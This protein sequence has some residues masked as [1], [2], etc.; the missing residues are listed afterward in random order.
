MSVEPIMASAVGNGR[1]LLSGR[2]VAVEVRRDGAVSN[3]P[4]HDRSGIL[5]PRAVPENPPR[6]VKIYER[7]FAERSVLHDYIQ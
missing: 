2:P 4:G 6:A 3:G 1:P 5:R 7:L